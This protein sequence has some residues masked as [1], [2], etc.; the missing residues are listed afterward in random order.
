MRDNSGKEE[1]KL[2]FLLKRAHQRIVAVASGA[3]LR[4]VE[5]PAAQA[6]ALVFLL[7]AGECSVNELGQLLGQGSAGITGL[8]GRLVKDGFVRKRTSPT[9]ARVVIL[10][11]TA[12]GRKVAQAAAAELARID[13]RMR[14]LVSRD[15]LAAAER[16]LAAVGEEGWE[17]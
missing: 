3:V 7:R 6:S 12:R 15:D 4:E 9:D 2:F 17:R 16:F 10:A 14:R 8:V 1:A 13:A 5:V 11:P